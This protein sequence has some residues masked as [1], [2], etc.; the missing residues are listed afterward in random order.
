MEEAGE[1]RLGGVSLPETY[2]D[3]VTYKKVVMSL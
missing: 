2:Q 1:R 3:M